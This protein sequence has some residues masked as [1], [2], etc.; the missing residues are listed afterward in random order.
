MGSAKE[1]NAMGSRVDGEVL[2]PE[3][4]LHKGSFDDFAA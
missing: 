4:G 1:Y 2:L 3:F